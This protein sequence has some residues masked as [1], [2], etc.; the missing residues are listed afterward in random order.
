MIRRTTKGEYCPT[1]SKGQAALAQHD[2]LGWYDAKLIR[3]L[4]RG[5]F[6]MLFV[7]PMARAVA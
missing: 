7:D 3:D 2:C 1:T 5:T 6:H 4:M